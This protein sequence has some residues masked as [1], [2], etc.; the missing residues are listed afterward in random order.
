MNGKLLI[1]NE[2]VLPLPAPWSLET[3]LGRLKF[4]VCTV[5][6]VAGAGGIAGLL[7][8]GSHEVPAIQLAHFPAMQTANAHL[9]KAAPDLLAA[10]L[11]IE[12]SLAQGA[13]ILETREQ[14]E[15]LKSALKRALP[16][17]YVKG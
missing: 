13:A 17:V 4:D 9:I 3:D 5:Y 14:H 1:S 16:Q 15:R 2:V 6:G 11:S 10:C 7:Y 12:A 8:V